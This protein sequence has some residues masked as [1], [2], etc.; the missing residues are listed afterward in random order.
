[1]HERSGGEGKEDGRRGWKSKN[2][3]EKS[4]RKQAEVGKEWGR[5]IVCTKRKRS[6]QKIEEKEKK[7]INTD[8]IQNKKLL[9]DWDWW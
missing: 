2:S 4:G 8:I 7:F 1:V 5:K 3:I 9:R 6:E